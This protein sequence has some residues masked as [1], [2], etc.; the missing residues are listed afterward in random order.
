MFIEMERDT[1]VKFNYYTPTEVV[2]GGQAELEVGNLVKRH[3]GSKVLVHYGG[4]SAKKSGLLDRV[5]KSLEAANID[6]VTLG[7]VVANPELTKI[8]E[9]I[10]LVK[11]ENID[12]ILA[13]GG[14]SVIDSSKA[15]GIGAVADRHIWEFIGVHDID[16]SLPVGSVLTLAAAGS[17][18][19][20]D[21][22]VT[23]DRTQVKR[24][25]G[26]PAVRPV[27]AALNPT[28]TYTLPKY[29]TSA[30]SADIIMHTVERYLVHGPTLD[31]TDKFAAA[32]VQ[33]VMKHGR[34]LLDDPENYQSRAEIMWSGSL[35]HNG[36][37]GTRTA[38][39]DWAS[40]LIGHELS[41]KYGLTHGASLTVIWP[42]WARYVCEHN[43][44]RFKQFAIE[45]MQVT[46]DGKSTDEII[47]AGISKLEKFFEELG[48]P[49]SLKD[50]DFE[51]SQEDI[52][53]MATK[54]SRNQ[55]FLLGNI[56]ELDYQDIINI[57][58][59]ANH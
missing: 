25:F 6:Y 27:F 48:M 37:T 19:S 9:G 54:A 2:F 41:A 45:V 12:F 52:E 26:G 8:E 53:D 23:N 3:N 59:K 50:V 18:M 46:E 1:M 10:E 58:N 38:A 11:K 39:G 15:I 4:N 24:N 30:G 20:D 57:F 44:D 7:G 34:I 47:E 55:T 29:H 40:H 31:L 28:L 17:E 32:L 33:N 35:S 36:L 5:F 16:K 43:K 51:V 22:V 14:G 49:T 56:K 42:T 21:T 13:V